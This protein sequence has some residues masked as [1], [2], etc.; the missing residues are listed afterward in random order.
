[1]SRI[2][3]V[4]WEESAK[5]CKPMLSEPI[6]RGQDPMKYNVLKQRLTLNYGYVI[7]LDVLH[8]YNHENNATYFTDRNLLFFYHC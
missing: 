6:G 4:H 7:P 1:M 8:I 5:G 2:N 3:G